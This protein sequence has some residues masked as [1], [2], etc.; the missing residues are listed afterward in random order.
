V[1]DARQAVLDVGLPEEVRREV[2]EVAEARLAR[3]QELLGLLPL[4]E[5]AEEAAERLRRLDQALVRLG[6]AM[7]GEGEQTDRPA[8]RDRR[9]GERGEGAVRFARR[10]GEHGLPFVLPGEARARQELLRRRLAREPAFLEGDGAVRGIDAK[11]APVL[12]ALDVADRTQAR[13]QAF[14]GSARLRK[15]TRDRVLEAQQLLAALLL[16]DVAADAVVA[17]EVALG[18][19]DRLARQGEPHGAAA[20][21]D[22]LDLEVAEAL[23]ALERA[24]VLFPVVVRRLEPGLLGELVRR[25]GEAELPVHLPVPVGKKAAER[26][27]VVHAVTWGSDRKSSKTA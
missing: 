25:I 2:G 21:R 6:S 16:A 1:H 4:Q 9:E 18:V 23:V 12:P 27:R 22:A 20:R 11:A 3:A 8:L 19:E 10:L 26:G 5:L 15:R 13:L 24:A 17:L 7:A 14:R